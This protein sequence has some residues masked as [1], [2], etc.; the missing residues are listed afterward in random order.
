MNGS[1]ETALDAS[2]IATRLWVG[3]APPVDRDLPD[4]DMLVLCAQEIQ[5]P[6][7]AFSRQLVRVPLPDAALSED[8]IRRAL[9][10]GRTV[11]EALTQGKRVL[12]T[13]YA[14]LNRSALVA[15]LGLGL[16]TQLGPLEIIARVRRRRSPDAL[17]NRYFVGLITK[18]VAG[19]GPAVKR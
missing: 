18:F 2:N 12:V 3:A 9:Q 17:S 1:K 19:G 4:F 10:G 14:G 5:P 15:S 16:V 13:C 7:L 6:V 11:A 8:Q